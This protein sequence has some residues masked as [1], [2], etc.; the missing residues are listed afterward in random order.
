MIILDF[1]QINVEVKNYYLIPN[2][3]GYMSYKEFGKKHYFTL[4]EIKRDDR[5]IVTEIKYNKKF[6]I[7]KISINIPEEK[8]IYYKFFNFFS[9][10]FDIDEDIADKMT[11]TILSEN[12]KNS[13]SKEIFSKENNISIESSS[14]ILSHLVQNKY[15]N[16]NY[17]II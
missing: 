13:M 17:Q 1:F 14:F 3:Y 7:Y 2:K 12:E 15:L 9:R 4:E 11:L 16:K 6:N 10:Y 5:F 8:K